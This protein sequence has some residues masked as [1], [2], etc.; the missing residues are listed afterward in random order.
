MLWVNPRE[1][2]ITLLNMMP[3]LTNLV[4]K[5]FNVLATND[6]HFIKI[7]FNSARDATTFARTWSNSKPHKYK[8]VI[9]KYVPEN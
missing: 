5:N 2:F 3:N 9:A 8:E 4:R 1:E 7:L 6:P